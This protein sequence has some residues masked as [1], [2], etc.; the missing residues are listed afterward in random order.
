MVHETAKEL[1]KLGGVLA[2]HAGK[3]R[4]VVVVHLLQRLGGGGEVGGDPQA[5]GLRENIVI[6]SCDV[7]IA[8]DG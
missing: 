3:E 5:D 1:A 4:W 8:G 6:Y 7:V 2:A